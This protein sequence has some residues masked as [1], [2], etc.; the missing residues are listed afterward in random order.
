MMPLTFT[1]ENMYA[2]IRYIFVDIFEID[3]FPVFTGN[4]LAIIA[5]MATVWE[6]VLLGFVNQIMME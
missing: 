2:W 6:G 5:L 4:T 1:A 3:R